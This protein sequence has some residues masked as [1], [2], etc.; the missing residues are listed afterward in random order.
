[1]NPDRFAPISRNFWQSWLA[2]HEFSF[3]G[4][5]L[6]PAV[7]ARPPAFFYGAFLGDLFGLLVHKQSWD[8]VWTTNQHDLTSFH[9]DDAR[10]C[11]FFLM[12]FAYLN[13]SSYRRE[14]LSS[15]GCCWIAGQWIEGTVAPLPLTSKRLGCH[16][17]VYVKTGG[18]GFLNWRIWG[19]DT[20]MRIPAPNGWLKPNKIM[21]CLLSTDGIFQRG[22]FKSR[23]LHFDPGDG[24]YTQ[25]LWQC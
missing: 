15:D 13:E 4:F 24:E 18:R 10:W 16:G 7:V 3:R 25:L 14:S 22:H 17:R 11:T 1:M 23:T 9:Y 21:G 20:W 6:L 12:F 5:G 19:K 8:A 2:L